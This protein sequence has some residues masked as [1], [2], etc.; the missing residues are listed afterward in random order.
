MGSEMCIRDR[1]Y[2]KV[3]GTFRINAA[4][5][6]NITAAK[7][8]E[9]ALK[10]AGLKKS[11]VYDLEADKEKERGTTFY[12]V[13]FETKNYEYEYDISLKGKILKKEVERD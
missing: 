8:K 12:E 10:D 4:S 11:Q 1:D 3:S 7:A 13:S 2:G 5:S 6:G 9:I